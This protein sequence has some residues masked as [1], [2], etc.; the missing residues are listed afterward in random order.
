MRRDFGTDLAPYVGSVDEGLG[1]VPLLVGWLRRGQP[2]QTGSVP[3]G[4]MDRL[5]PFCHEA[6]VVGRTAGRRPCEL[7]RQC[8]LPPTH[9]TA[10]IRV[11]GDEDIYAA[12]TLIYHYVTIHNY[13]PPDEFIT[14]VLH[15]P[16]AGS[17]E[18]R[19]LIKA[20]NNH[21]S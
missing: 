2:F 14:A 6:N 12:P 10:E 3:A 7:D 20:L 13:K 4:F 5:L 8:Q 16:P 18:H 17:P 11:I 21:R 15:G 1:Y 9:L 19:A